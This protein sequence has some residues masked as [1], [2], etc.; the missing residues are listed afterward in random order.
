MFSI[1][2]QDNLPKQPT[3]SLEKE[4]KNFFPV[5]H[6]GPKQDGN[7]HKANS[8]PWSQEAP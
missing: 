6:V 2:L 7:D 3:P 8:G 4:P 1:L 5:H